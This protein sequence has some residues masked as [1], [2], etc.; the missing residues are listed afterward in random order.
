M[1]DH[2]IDNS[3]DLDQLAARVDAVWLALCTLRDELT[4]STTP[5]D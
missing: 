1:A 5:S 2:V 3:G 4:A